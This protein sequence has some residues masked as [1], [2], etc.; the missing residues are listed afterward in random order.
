MPP[1]PTTLVSSY[2]L[3]IT[4]S[5]TATAL[6]FPHEAKPELPQG[7]GERVFPH[8][9][10]LVQLGVGDDERAKD[11]DRVPVHARL[12]EQEAAVAG[13]VDHGLRELG[14]GRLRRAVLDELDRDHGAEPAH[15]ADRRES[16][17]PR[18]H[19]RPHRLAELQRA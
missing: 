16:L 11:A 4:W 18:Q 6:W 3:A 10:R 7:F 8:A 19:P 2:R 5:R 1:V 13:G 17:L 12:Q 9:E 15:V 14:R